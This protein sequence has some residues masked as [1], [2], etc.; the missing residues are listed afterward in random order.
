[1]HKWYEVYRA[2][3]GVFLLVWNRP[4][5]HGRRNIPRNGAAILAS[6]HQAVLDSFF[7]PLMLWRHLTFP[8][9]KEYFTSP[10]IG[11]RLQKFFFT[12][13]GQIPVDR[14]SAGAADD[15]QR[16]AKEV[17]DDGRLLGIYPEGTR[18]PDGRLYKGKTGM[19]RLAMTNNVDVIPVAMI[20]TRKANPIG[21]FFPR[22]RH[23]SMRI[24]EPINPHAWAREHGFDPD[25]REV[26]RPF[27]D[28]VMHR[29]QELS[30]YPYVDAYAADVK[31][32]LEAG[33][34]YPEGTEPTEPT[35]PT[36]P[37]AR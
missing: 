14:S 20:N 8:A 10:G 29:I 22:P 23:V 5:I 9:K 1:M 19:A 21:T 30:G 13:V 15:L 32:S 12:S 11:G 6:N 17:F 24:G 28:Y 2:T 25:S 26:M 33:L 7:L 37:E 27:T 3:L 31:R 16:A 34:G 4:T 18:S 36:G 35:G